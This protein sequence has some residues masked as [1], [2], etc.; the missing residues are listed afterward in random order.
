MIWP[1]CHAS[2]SLTMASTSSSVTYGLFGWSTEKDS[3][4]KA[5]GERPAGREHHLGS[6][7]SSSSMAYSCELPCL[8]PVELSNEKGDR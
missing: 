6:P 3:S 4:V 2:T 7:F 1:L 5:V 8:K